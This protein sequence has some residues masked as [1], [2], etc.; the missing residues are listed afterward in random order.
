M[1][2]LPI[3]ILSLNPSKK[4]DE[5]Y[6]ADSY[7][8][9]NFDWS[10][11]PLTQAEVRMRELKS[12]AAERQELLKND[13]APTK[14]ALWERGG[15]G[16][17]SEGLPN[18]A[19]GAK[20]PSFDV[21]G[22][23]VKGLGIIAVDLSDP[24]Q[25]KTT[26]IHEL[27]HEVQDIEEF[28]GGSSPDAWDGTKQERF[29]NYYYTAGEVEARLASEPSPRGR[30]DMTEEERRVS[31]PL[32]GAPGVVYAEDAPHAA[33]A[34]FYVKRGENGNSNVVVIEE[35]IFKRR[36]DEKPHKV[37]R[38]YL[39]K[40]IGE[41]ATIIE[42]GQKV[43]FGKDL[44]GEFTHSKYSKNLSF[45]KRN[46]KSQAAQNLDELI[47]IGTNRRWSKNRKAKHEIDAKYGFYQ[48]TTRFQVSGKTYDADILIRN[49]ADGKK[50]LYDIINIK[51]EQNALA[52]NRKT[53]QLYSSSAPAVNSISQSDSA[54]NNS[55]RKN[56]G[57]VYNC[58]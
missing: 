3:K 17:K 54:V 42:S 2:A 35:D 34:S 32:D 6:G 41:F 18:K 51:Q 22:G 53:V 12:A 29:Q 58:Q 26:L 30:L 14:R 44:P 13:K 16:R 24:V 5:E 11:S 38:D 7:G 33:G 21:I 25:A 50:Y 40:H 46:A 48:Y 49:D 31:Y 57:N 45:N 23:H 19:S 28:T 37:I 9:S 55:V 56:G 43:Y 47:G 52:S 36:E 4:I 10:V 27:Q 39:K 8:G 15:T 20:S 1:G